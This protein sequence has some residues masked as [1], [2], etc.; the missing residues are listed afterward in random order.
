[1]QSDMKNIEATLAS[2][3]DPGLNEIV[4]EAGGLSDRHFIVKFPLN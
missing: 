2:W 3:L 4:V 1:M